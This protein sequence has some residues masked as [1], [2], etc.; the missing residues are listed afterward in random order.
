MIDGLSIG[1]RQTVEILKALNSKASL[2]IMDEPTSSLTSTEAAQLFGIIRKLKAEGISVL[3][4]SHRMEEVYEL[5]DRVT[6]LR[7]GSLMAV[8]DKAQIEPAEIIRLMIG[9]K[10]DER[11]TIHRMRKPS[12]PVT[13]EVKGLSSQG[14]FSD[15]SFSLHAGEILGIGGLVGSGRTELVRALY[16]IGRQGLGPGQ[17]PG[18]GLDSGRA[19]VN[20]G[21]LWLY[22]RGA[23]PPGHH[24][25]DQHHRQ[26][27][28]HQ[29]RWH[30]EAGLRGWPEGAG[31]GPKGR[32][33]PEHKAD[34]P[35][36]ARRQ[37]LGRQPAEGRGGESG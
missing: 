27:R 11:D 1:Q 10:L 6:V 26:Y 18:Q 31:P 35:L 29:P 21:G 14:K 34:R 30:Q 2:V 25:R 13:L 8:L 19:P 5:S 22:P 28:D 15:I 16:G 24:G 23:P 9:R 3:Y 37:P 17:L 32:G 4:I 20:P 33:P 12:G 36:G 7:D